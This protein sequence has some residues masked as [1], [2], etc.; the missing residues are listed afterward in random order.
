MGG[1]PQVQGSH[2]RVLEKERSEEDPLL[3]L[4]GILGSRGRQKDRKR[5]TKK[6]RS[7]E[8]KKGEVKKEER[9]QE[10]SGNALLETKSWEEWS[11]LTPGQV[12]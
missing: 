2:E 7:K 12:P 6:E 5:G 3:P 1:G 4:T 10:C 9:D 11:A 8:G